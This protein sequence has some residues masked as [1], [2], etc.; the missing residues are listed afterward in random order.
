MVIMAEE[1]I[2][3]KVFVHVKSDCR[4]ILR[5]DDGEELSDDIIEPGTH[6]YEETDK[7]IDDKPTDENIE[8]LKILFGEA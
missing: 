5:R 4:R 1:T 7:T 8:A 3:G 6:T 2:V